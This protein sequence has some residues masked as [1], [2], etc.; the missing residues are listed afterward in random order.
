MLITGDAGSGKSSLGL[1]LMGYG[2]AL[3]ADDQVRL[4]AGWGTLT[5]SCPST[6]TGLIEAR[7]IGILKADHIASADVQLVV[8]LNVTETQRLPER[9]VITLLGC[10]R[11]L[12][13]RGEGPRF[14]AALLQTLKAGWSDR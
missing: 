10:E 6:I 3:V 4:K 1:A 9:R 8:D 5:A 2:C 14:A 11:P 7:G 13:Y 12:I